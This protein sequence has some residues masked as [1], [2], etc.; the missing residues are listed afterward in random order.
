MLATVYYPCSNFFGDIMAQDNTKTQDSVQ[1]VLTG[2]DG[3]VK[4]TQSKKEK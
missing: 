1:I 2:P 4:K 3:K